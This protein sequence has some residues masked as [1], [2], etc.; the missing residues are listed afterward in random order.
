[1]YGE[2][3]GSV[4]RAGGEGG[5]AVVE[6]GIDENELELVEVDLGS[7]HLRFDESSAHS[8]TSCRY[9]GRRHAP[10]HIRGLW[11]GT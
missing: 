9:E 4:A 3:R 11:T 8:N 7:S 10:L 1:M 6:A 5:E 2:Y